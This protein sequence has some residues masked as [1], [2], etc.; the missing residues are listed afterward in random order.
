MDEDVPGAGELA[1]AALVH[2]A[3]REVGQAIA[4]LAARPLDEAA[5]ERMRHALTAVS[6][7]AREALQRL[8]SAGSDRPARSGGHQFL[9]V[10]QAAAATATR[11][12]PA[13]PGEGLA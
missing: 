6:G 1:D 12:G 2:S 4:A 5:A 9:L 11:S 3:R 10:D 7:P 8:R 13:A